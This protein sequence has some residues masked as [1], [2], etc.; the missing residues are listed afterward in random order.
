MLARLI[1]GSAA[2]VS[3]ARATLQRVLDECITDVAA[4]FGLDEEVALK[5]ARKE[6]LDVLEGELASV[7]ELGFAFRRAASR[8]SEMGGAEYLRGHEARHPGARP[9]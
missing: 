2:E 5:R 4:K 8:L 3:S 1:A 7:Q 9:L 6:E